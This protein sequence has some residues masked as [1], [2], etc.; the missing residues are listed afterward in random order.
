MV[1]ESIEFH[2]DALCLLKELLKGKIE[3]FEQ[4]KIFVKNLEEEIEFYECQIVGAV[5]EGKRGFDRYK[6][7]MSRGRSD[8]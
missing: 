8:D 1:L 2:Y 4:L 5:S 6:Y 7:G 3:E